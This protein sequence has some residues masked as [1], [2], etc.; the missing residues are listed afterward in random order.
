MP[1]VPQEE[2]REDT[3]AFFVAVLL[4]LE[5]LGP[6]ALAVALGAVALIITGDPVT[7][8]PALASLGLAEIEFS[9]QTLSTAQLTGA[10]WV[11]I[12]AIFYLACIATAAHASASP[13][14]GPGAL[15]GKT[16]WT[17]SRRS[18]LWQRI[19]KDPTLTPQ[20]FVQG[21]MC[22]TNDAK[23]P[24]SL[25]LLADW[26]AR[27]VGI[28][29]PSTTEPAEASTV[30]YEELSVGDVCAWLSKCVFAAPRERLTPAQDAELQSMVRALEAA[31]APLARRPGDVD[32]APS[33]TFRT[34]PGIRGVCAQL[35]P[36]RWRHRPLAYYAVSHGLGA[37]AYTRG[38]MESAGFER[39]REKEL[40][41]WYKPSAS[42]AAA[43]DA[44]IFVH[45]IGLGPAPY[46]SFV[47]DCT[48]DSTPVMVVEM[49]GFSQRL[50]P[51]MPPSPERFASLL[52]DALARLGIERAVLAG[53]SLGSTFVNYAASRDR[54][55]R[56][57]VCGVVLL[58]PV[59]CLLHHSTTTAEFVYNTPATLEDALM[60]YVFKK[61]LWS[62]IVVS[63][64]LPWHEAGVWLEDCSKQVPTL[65]A[66]G[67]QDAIVA[68]ARVRA[69]F[70]SWQARLRGVRVVWMSGGH[71]SWLGDE[72]LNAQL[73]GSVRALRSEVA[74]RRRR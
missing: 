31:G 9:L 30:A 24:T 10:A 38:V 32:G 4:F 60:D 73:V 70:G 3:T 54:E 55:R 16:E 1:D 35:D 8:G 20:Q 28:Q 61:E 40:S 62:A 13:G 29:S 41:Y 18:E 39:R 23:A 37:T 72:D 50:F 19:V 68:P 2:S 27:R 25:S 26:A 43:G 15:G 14:H 71:G 21:W 58:D 36:V 42:A 51:R 59:A 52:D 69:A 44:L 22:R 63:R 53:H 7:G 65:V 47:K 46:A 5:L 33:A 57:R 67:A 64:H 12:E 34:T 6:L 17:A 11:G 45:G 56:Q 49:E 74:A 66:V 48:D